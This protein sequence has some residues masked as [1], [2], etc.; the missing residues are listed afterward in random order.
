MTA[1]PPMWVRG[2]R[3]PHMVS[4]SSR[5]RRGRGWCDAPGAKTSCRGCRRAAANGRYCPREIANHGL[6]PRLSSQRYSMDQGCQIGSPLWKSHSRS[7][8]GVRCGAGLGRRGVALAKTRFFPA[9]QQRLPSGPRV[10]CGQALGS[11]LRTAAGD[12]R[13]VAASAREAETRMAAT[14]RAMIRGCMR[15][16]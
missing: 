14:A 11:S 9:I 8:F 6:R 4:L 13:H 5:A 3:H 15:G 16:V 2:H 12:G 10:H 7:A 1:L